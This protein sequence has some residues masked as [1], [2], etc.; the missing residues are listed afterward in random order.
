MAR[1]RAQVDEATTQRERGVAAL[2]E[3]LS[4]VEA[5]LAHRRK[6]ATAQAAAKKLAEAAAAE[7]ATEAAQAKRGSKLRR[8]EA[9]VLEHLEEGAPELGTSQ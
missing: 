9:A 7:A 2:R 1:L 5:E 6:G 4:A 3:E 8:A